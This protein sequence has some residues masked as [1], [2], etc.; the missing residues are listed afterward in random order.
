M[1]PLCRLL[2]IPFSFIPCVLLELLQSAYLMPFLLLCSG[3][4]TVDTRRGLRK[5]G[6][7]RRPTVYTD[8]R[9]QQTRI[10]GTR[11]LM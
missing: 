5:E 3:H 9:E 4:E 11:R 10:V 8:L 6:V 1:L 2:Y 7:K